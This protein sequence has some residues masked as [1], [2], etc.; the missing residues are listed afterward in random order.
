[1]NE[2][3][4][5]RTQQSIDYYTKCLKGAKRA[6]KLAE[7]L[8]E[9]IQNLAIDSLYLSPDQRELILYVFG[10][11]AAC[12]TLKECGVIGFVPHYS[13]WHKA[14]CLTD[15]VMDLTK[16]CTATFTVYETSKPPKCHVE[17]REKTVVEEIAICEETGKEV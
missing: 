15:G 12:Q 3:L 14:W 2:D 11:D 6:Q 10:G 1:M 17:K 8:P 4:K 9:E 5:K 16:G 7:F 13:N